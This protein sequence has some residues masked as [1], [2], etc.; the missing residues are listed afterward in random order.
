[1]AA[2]ALRSL[3]TSTEGQIPIVFR[4]FCSESLAATTSR[5]A[6]KHGR[7]KNADQQEDEASSEEVPA[8]SDEESNSSLTISVGKGY[9]SDS[10]SGRDADYDSDSTDDDDSAQKD[11]ETEVGML[12]W[13]FMIF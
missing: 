5:F 4:T 8:L 2:T 9:E 1:M 11:P 12:D 10:E 13:V 7:S 3:V 6:E